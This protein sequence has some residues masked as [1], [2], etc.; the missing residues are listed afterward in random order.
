M[1]SSGQ[2]L[3]L[4]VPMRAIAPAVS[5]LDTALCRRISADNPALRLLTRYVSVAEET[6]TFSS[7]ELQQR[8]VTHIHDLIALTIGATRDGVEIARKRGAA[9]A[10]LRAIKADITENI[11]C[12]DLSV[13]IVAARHRLQV[14]Y[15]QRL[16]EAEGTSFTQF[17]LE[18]RLT[19]ARQILLNPRLVHFKMSMVAIEAGFSN[20]SY[21]YE[22]FRR[23]FGAAPSDVRAQARRDH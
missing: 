15:V 1:I 13:A 23:R 16:F 8:A 7:Q 6:D 17:V 14:R 2:S 12:E 22:T 9:A 19:R 20:I 4:R 10:R 18:Q 21:F 5:G 3:T 11:S